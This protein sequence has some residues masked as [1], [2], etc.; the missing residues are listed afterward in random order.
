MANTEQ[1]STE[2]RP[3]T[4]ILGKSLVNPWFA[5]LTTCASIIESCSARECE[6]VFH[7]LIILRKRETIKEGLS[8]RPEC[9]ARCSR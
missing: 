9:D 1:R 5:T 4:G 8:G 3:Q 2:S 7:Y 6:I